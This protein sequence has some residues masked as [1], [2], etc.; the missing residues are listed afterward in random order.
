MELE[1]QLVPESRAESIVRT[2]RTV[3]GDDLRSV[4]YFTHDRCEQIYLRS[5][6]EADADLTGFVEHETDGFQA[7]TAYRG[8]ELGNY[9]YTVRAFEHGYLTRVTVA[10]NGVFVT[11]DGLTLR[12]SEELASALSELLRVE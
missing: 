12:R 1:S 11:T 6:L 5:D 3:V 4:T 2:C 10:S 7:R 9:R 8:S